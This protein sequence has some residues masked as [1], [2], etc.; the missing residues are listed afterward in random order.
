MMELIDVD[1]HG[2]IFRIFTIKVFDLIP[3]DFGEESFMK[4]YF[5]IFEVIET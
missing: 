3:I 2:V 1:E 5:L 4:Q